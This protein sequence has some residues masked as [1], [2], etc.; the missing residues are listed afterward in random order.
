MEDKLPHIYTNKNV[1]SS[2]NR[3]FYYSLEDKD[4]DK[5]KKIK[6]DTKEEILDK[7]NLRNTIKSNDINTKIINIFKNSNSIYKIG[8]NIN[9]NGHN[10]EKYLIGRTNNT[11]ITID[12]EIINIKDIDDINLI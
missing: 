4:P 6:K 12:G 7:Y 5:N 10:V 3:K 9:I 1:I 2:N 11:L 8:V